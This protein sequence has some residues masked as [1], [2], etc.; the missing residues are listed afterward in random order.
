MSF[1]LYFSILHYWPPLW[2]AFAG[3][4]K[5]RSKIH[6]KNRKSWPTLV[7]KFLLTWV[8]GLYCNPGHAALDG[9]IL[10]TIFLNQQLT[11][12][13][14]LV[15]AHLFAFYVCLVLLKEIPSVSARKRWNCIWKEPVCF[16][17]L[18]NFYLHFLED[19]CCRVSCQWLDL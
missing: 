2:R 15:F 11:L 3:Q 6:T 8:C 19:F 7:K 12:C 17:K 13:S 10:W 14:S 5:E 1:Q 16:G 9:A 4:K 18:C